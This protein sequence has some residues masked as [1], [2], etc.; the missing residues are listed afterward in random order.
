M[1]TGLT[2][3]RVDCP[4]CGS[5]LNR[6]EGSERELWS[7]RSCGL[8]TELKPHREPLP[9]VALES[10]PAEQVEQDE[11][12]LDRWLSGKPIERK[13]PS[14]S[15]R[16]HHWTQDNWGAV[17]CFLIAL[18]AVS[19]F[20][21]HAMQHSVVSHRQLADERAAHE[22]TLRQAEERQ[23]Q[24]RLLVD[25][26]Q[27]KSRSIN[28]RLEQA[29]I[30]MRRDL[31]DRLADEAVRLEAVA[32]QRSLLLAA[33]AVQIA[34]DARQHPAV[35]AVQILFDQ[36]QSHS[37]PQPSGHREEIRS[38]AFS[39]DGSMWAT[40][41]DDHRA[42]LH[43]VD[44]TRAS[45]PLDAHW[46]RVSQVKFSPDSRRLAT[47]SF[48]ATI[49][50]WNVQASQAGQSPVVLEGHDERVLSIDFSADSRWLLSSAQAAPGSP[51]E[52]FL[53]DLQ[54][55]GGPQIRQ[56]LGRHFGRVHAAKLSPDGRWAFTSSADQYV[57]LWRLNPKS[58]DH[59]SVAARA[60]HGVTDQ[61]CFSRDSSQLITVSEGEQ[62]RAVVRLWQLG[63]MVRPEVVA[64]LP[65][66]PLA[67]DAN[68]AR[69][70]IAIGGRQGELKVVHWKSG[71]V[72]SVVGHDQ[73]L[74]LVRFLPDG[75]LASI[76]DQ[77]K[78]R[79]TSLSGGKMALGVQLPNIAGQADAVSISPDGQMA[80]VANEKMEV[81]VRPLD[82]A[83]LTRVAFE[84]LRSLRGGVGTVAAQADAVRR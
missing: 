25:S 34:H 19:G 61:V 26:A 71:A 46:S 33:E 53:W 68:F 17:T 11:D 58:G 36:L 3:R 54:A 66:Q 60:P 40:G 35:G 9:E 74:R 43:S 22:E 21:A 44:G 63:E 7:C 24:L 13:A 5:A 20:A 78:V 37:P 2:S 16:L 52:I 82:P 45:V 32:P 65:I 55:A 79:R 31:A 30:E 70:M 48:D 10:L 75:Q 59:F 6:D 77:G 80:A 4:L 47:A 41:G 1:Q 23:E 81:V 39:A 12:Q 76:D 27:I 69:E 8:S 83:I 42:I 64:S 72:V 51:S 73:T 62:G 28:K 50:L 56:T 38:I 84:R 15:R 14:I 29:R 49:C 67:V 18:L 57:Q